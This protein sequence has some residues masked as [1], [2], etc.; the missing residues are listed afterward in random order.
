MCVH[1]SML[2]WSIFTLRRNTPR[3]SDRGDGLK[4]RKAA[5]NIKNK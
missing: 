1:V 5:V 2:R 3:A 4:G